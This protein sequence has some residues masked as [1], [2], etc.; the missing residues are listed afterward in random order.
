MRVI[1]RNTEETKKIAAKAAKDF[2]KTGAGK[3]AAVFAL[4]GDLGSGKTTFVQGFYSGLG[5]KKRAMSPTFIILRRAAFNKK[6]FKNIF[7]MDAYRLKS[8]KEVRPLE[9]KKLFK[10][11][12]NIILIEWPENIKSVLPKKT[13][14]IKFFHEKKE[15]ERTLIF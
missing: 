5:L 3:T 13:V 4:Q 6:G 10:N 2:L 8:G 7:H 14:W 12:E 9:L 11:P 1:T 15:K